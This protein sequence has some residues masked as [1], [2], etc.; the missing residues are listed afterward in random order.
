MHDIQEFQLYVIF[1]RLLLH[2]ILSQIDL[3]IIFSPED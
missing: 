3:I 1:H 2:K